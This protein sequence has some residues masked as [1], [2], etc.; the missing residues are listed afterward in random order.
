MR[1]KKELIVV[2]AALIFISGCSSQLD[3]LIEIDES[4]QKMEEERKQETSSYERIKK[5]VSKG[6]L[7]EGLEAATIQKKYGPP[8]VVLVK[9]EGTTKWVYKP[10]KDDFFKPI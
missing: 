3:T 1:F 2:F 5:A 7:T 6:V 8:V 10:A 4:Q 9:E